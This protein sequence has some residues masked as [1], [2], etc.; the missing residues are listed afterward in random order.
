MCTI[1]APIHVYVCLLSVYLSSVCMLVCTVSCQSVTLVSHTTCLSFVNVYV[2]TCPPNLSYSCALF[3]TITC[4]SVDLWHPALH[5]LSVFFFVSVCQ[6]TRLSVTFIRTI[7]SIY[8]C[9]SVFFCVHM[10][11]Y[12][13]HSYVSVCLS[14]TFMYTICPFRTFLRLSVDLRVFVYVY[15]HVNILHVQLFV[16]LLISYIRA[17]SSQYVSV[18]L[19]V[20]S[21][22]FRLCL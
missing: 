19:A 16:R 7:S 13:V 8:V 22:K 2:G 1:S 17:P 14:A 12:H 9:V 18:C 4:P 11:V 5:S 10:S 3:P 6:Y 15:F 21:S 20:H